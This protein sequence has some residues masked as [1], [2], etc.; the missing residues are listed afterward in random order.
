MDGP[1]RAKLVRAT[2][3][4]LTIAL[5]Q[6]HKHGLKTVMSRAVESQCV[7]TQLHKA[8]ELL[9]RECDRR[10]WRSMDLSRLKTVSHELALEGFS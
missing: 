6:D 3:D 10:G 7:G 1:Y 2:D 4:I 8:T 9:L 5:L